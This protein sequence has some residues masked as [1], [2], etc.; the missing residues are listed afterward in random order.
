[1]RLLTSHRIFALLSAGGV[2]LAALIVGCGSDSP[3][4]IAADP[5]PEVEV[6]PEEAPPSGEYGSVVHAD[7]SN[8]EELV[9]RAEGPVLV[10][11]YADWCG[12]CRIQAPI[13][14]DFARETPHV[15][16]VKVN[17]D[18][19][20]NLA[21]QYSVTAIPNLKVFRDGEVVNEHRGVAQKGRLKALVDV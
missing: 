16:I 6:A 19:A 17:F 21:R 9:L 4:P 1:M 11:F 18:E 13:L 8:F 2:V 15:L 20:R 10:Y 7:E 5:T 3:A 12:P 14:D